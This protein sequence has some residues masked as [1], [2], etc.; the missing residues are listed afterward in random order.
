MADEGLLGNTQLNF[1]GAQDGKRIVCV[2]AAITARA[3]RVNHS[4]QEDAGADVPVED[5][6]VCGAAQRNHS[7]RFAAVWF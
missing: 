4:T 6:G 5:S 1:V 2:T 7:V 3:L